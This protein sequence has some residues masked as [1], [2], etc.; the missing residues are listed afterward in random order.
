M[1]Q[2]SVSE[3]PVPVHCAMASGLYRMQ[4]AALPVLHAQH[5]WQVPC[6]LL[7]PW[8][9]ACSPAVAFAA[10]SFK[11][12]VTESF[13]VPMYQDGWLAMT[14]LSVT[15]SVLSTYT[16]SIPIVYN[17][18]A[19]SQLSTAQLHTVRPVRSG[20]KR[21]R[22]SNELSSDSQP[23]SKRDC[24]PL[25]DILA[26][27]HSSQYAFCLNDNLLT[28]HIGFGLLSVRSAAQLC[29][30]HE[31]LLETESAR[32]GGSKMQRQQWHSAAWMQ[33]QQG[34]ELICKH[35]VCMC[36]STMYCGVL[37]VSLE[38]AY[39]GWGCLL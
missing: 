3:V 22:D 11:L 20:T 10:C 34:P 13:R 29:C 38:H 9:T 5:R 16:V 18:S 32:T 39:I 30:S 15:P 2:P 8:P 17:H 25:L 4:G 26:L 6:W 36:T 37:D 35:T 21:S 24:G 28:M 23:A 12:C 1:L 7:K 19:N 31:H 33:Y 14:E 27:R